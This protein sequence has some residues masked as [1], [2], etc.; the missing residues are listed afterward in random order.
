VNPQSKEAV[1]GDWLQRLHT[2]IGEPDPCDNSDE[3]RRNSISS[4]NVTNVTGISGPFSPPLDAEGVPC[5]LCP[6]CNQ[7][8]FWRRPKF[9]KDHDPTGWICWFCKPPGDFCSDFC[10]V[11]DEN[12]RR[13]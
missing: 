1:M 9:H 11:L 6:S 4:H 7:G 10:G 13:R 3:M 12:E 2:L 8:E 5:G